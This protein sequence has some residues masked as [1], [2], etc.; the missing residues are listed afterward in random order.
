[1]QLPCPKVHNMIQYNDMGVDAEQD[2][3]YFLPKLAR[4]Q[5]W[6]NQEDCII[7]IKELLTE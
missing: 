1:M 3:V 5:N 4:R 6:H 7:D 2:Q